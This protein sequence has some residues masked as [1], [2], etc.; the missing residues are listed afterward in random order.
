MES[1]TR[2]TTRF[3]Q[4]GGNYLYEAKRKILGDL[5]PWCRRALDW[6]WDTDATGY[7][8]DEEHGTYFPEK[9]RNSLIPSR[10]LFR[11]IASGL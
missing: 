5:A 6:V 2:P 8:L 4:S 11:I 7:V 1:A 3:L 9:F 10:N